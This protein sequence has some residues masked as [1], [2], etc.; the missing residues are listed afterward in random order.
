M[1]SSSCFNAKHHGG[2][3]HSL[4]RLSHFWGHSRQYV[5]VKH[6]SF[7]AC[8]LNSFHCIFLLE[9]VSWSTLT[10]EENQNTTNTAKRIG[11]IWKK[12]KST[13][14]NCVCGRCSSAEL[15]TLGFPCRV[16]IEVPGLVASISVFIP[17]IRRLLILSSLLNPFIY[18][19]RQDEMKT[20]AFRF[21]RQTEEPPANWHSGWYKKAITNDFNI[22]NQEYCAGKSQTR[23]DL[24]FGQYAGKVE[25]S[26]F[27]GK[28]RTFEVN[29]FFSCYMA[30]LLF[31]ICKSLIGLW[32]L[33]EDNVPYDQQI[34]GRVTVYRL[35]KQAI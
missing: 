9:F 12:K 23:L 31:F 35:Q 26:W 27:S 28:D 7:D 16:K 1:L 18:C 19:W 34:R 14:D 29:N 24:S 30:V 11:K 32:A 2:S 17:W 22:I 21:M 4:D 3:D 15:C 10:P 33:R 6:N 13:Q 5:N 20:C 25:V 8:F